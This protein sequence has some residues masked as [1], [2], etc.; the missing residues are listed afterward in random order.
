VQ[1]LHCYADTVTFTA[2]TACDEVRIDRL[3]V[4]AFSMQ[5]ES[6]V[7]PATLEPR[8][9]PDQTR[10]DPPDIETSAHTTTDELNGQ[11]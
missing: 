4:P 2:Y 11:A 3:A 5:G 8:T 6:D 1:S 9:S 7:P 10:D